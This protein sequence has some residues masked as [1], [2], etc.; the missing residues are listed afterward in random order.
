MAGKDGNAN[1]R[2]VMGDDGSGCGSQSRGNGAN[3]TR[4]R[5][6]SAATKHGLRA[7]A[8]RGKPQTQTRSGQIGSEDNLRVAR[9]QFRDTL[10]HRLRVADEWKIC[11][12]QRFERRSYCSFAYSALAC[13]T[14]GMSGSASF[15]SV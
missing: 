14:T 5:G 12:L 9:P 15:Q 7:I 13:L 6:V 1:Q 2:V 11:L 3:R 8:R 10:I 4:M